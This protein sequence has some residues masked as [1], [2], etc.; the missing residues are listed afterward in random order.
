[1]EGRARV[2]VAMSGGV[3]SSVAAALCVE[4]GFSAMGVTLKLLGREETGFGCCG[5]PVD[6][7]DARRVCEALGIPH[8]VLNLADIFEDKVI[9]PFVDSYLSARTPNPCVEC[10]RS[11]KFGYLLG[12]AEAWG[13]RAVATGH[14]A[15]VQDGRL[16]RA[17]DASKDQTYF[18]YSLTRRELGQVMFPVG[19]LTKAEV[20]RKARELGLRTAEKPES[21]E[22]CFVPRRDYRSFLESRPEALQGAQA[23]GPGPIKDLEG[24][25]LGRH[26]GLAGY[27]VGQRKGLGSGAQ[28]PRFVVRLEPET[29]TLVVGGRQD[30]LTR[31]AALEAVSWTSTPPS[32]PIRA[33]VRIRHRHEPAV[34]EV[35]PLPGSAAEV[36]FDEPQRAAAPGQAAVF[37]DGD[38]VLGGGIISRGSK[39]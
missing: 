12:L 34:A 13:A 28:A 19:E 22:I 31:R 7:D 38:E 29:G 8:Y 18:L 39:S 30:V 9:R 2:V 27:T 36:V 23:L 14:Y 35:S 11:L 25:S 10:N 20:R 5:S 1:M 16:W 21:Q 4:Q 6:I 33:R 37:Y 24:R 26:G 3:D 32:G 17:R 15:R